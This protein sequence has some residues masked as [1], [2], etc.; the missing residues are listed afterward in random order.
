MNG[1]ALLVQITSPIKRLPCS[2][3]QADSLLCL[4]WLASE[5]SKEGMKKTDAFKD[6]NLGVTFIRP[7]TLLHLRLIRGTLNFFNIREMRP[8]PIKSNFRLRFMYQYVLNF[9]R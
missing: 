8:I 3:S 5:V 1:D 4:D 9:S 7:Q 6:Q 2:D